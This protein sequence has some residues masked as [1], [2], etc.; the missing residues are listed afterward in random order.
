MRFAA[1]VALT[2]AV[3]L[4]IAALATRFSASPGRSPAGGSAPGVVR[5]R[6]RAD[7]AA[8]HA[9]IER[10]RPVIAAERAVIEAERRAIQSDRRSLEP[11]ARRIE[12]RRRRGVLAVETGLHRRD[13][14]EYNRRSAALH[15]RIERFNRRVEAQQRAVEEFN[16]LVSRYNAGR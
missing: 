4:G 12:R 11:L 14:L 10:Q 16:A 1:A 8:L 5:T 3:S 6:A 7:T 13:M 15:A 2:V 9:E